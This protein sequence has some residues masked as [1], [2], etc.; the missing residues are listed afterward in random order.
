MTVHTG[1]LDHAMMA[2][3]HSDTPHADSVSFRVLARAED[4]TPTLYRVTAVRVGIEF[5]S[6]A[7][8]P[9]EALRRAVALLRAA[10]GVDLAWDELTGGVTS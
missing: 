5:T 4:G 10:A 8:T 3:L 2:A 7:T 6:Q 9:T 1:D